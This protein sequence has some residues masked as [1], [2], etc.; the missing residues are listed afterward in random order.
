LVQNNLCQKSHYRTWTNKNGKK[1]TV[2][3]TIHTYIRH[4]N[5]HG[6]SENLNEIK[7]SDQ[8]LM[9]SINFLTDLLPKIK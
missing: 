3:M 2:H 8:E 6:P 4:W 1:I 7:Y 9:D 5:H